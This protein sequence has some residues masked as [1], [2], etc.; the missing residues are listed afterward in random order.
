[1]WFKSLRKIKTAEEIS[2]EIDEFAEKRGSSK[3][4]N[5]LKNSLKIDLFYDKLFLASYEKDKNKEKQLLKQAKEIADKVPELKGWPEDKKKFWSI[6]AYRWNK[7]IPDKVRSGIS[8]ELN[9]LIKTNNNLS[10]G[11]G[12]YPYLENSVLIDFSEEMLKEAK[13]AKKKVLWDINKSLPFEKEE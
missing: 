3:E 13:N 12:S 8:S 5:E 2:K 7:T 1:M 6:E 9:N 11:S 4:I 10:L